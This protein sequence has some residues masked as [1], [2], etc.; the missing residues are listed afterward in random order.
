MGEEVVKPRPSPSQEELRRLFRLD[1]KT[2]KLYWKYD[3]GPRARK[4]AEAGGKDGR[5]YVCV[6][7]DG[8][9]YKVHR[10]VFVMVH[11]YDAAL[12]HHVNEDKSDNRPKN[13]E[14]STKSRNI[15]VLFGAILRLRRGLSEDN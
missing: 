13:L 6:E 5:G 8:L 2:G 3:K 4:G 15:D 14:A 12:V 10:L 1:R 9:G 11:G 7:I